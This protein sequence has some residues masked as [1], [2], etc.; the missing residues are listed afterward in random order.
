MKRKLGDF[1]KF[2]RKAKR[3]EGEVNVRIKVFWHSMYSIVMEKYKEIQ[4]QR[5]V[6]NNAT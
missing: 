4:K 6:L 1:N 5:S 3:T 2:Y